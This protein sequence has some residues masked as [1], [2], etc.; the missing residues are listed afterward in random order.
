MAETTRRTCPQCGKRLPQDAPGGL[1][2]RCVMAMNLSAETELTGDAGPVLVSPEEIAARLPQYEILE[3]LGRGGMGVVYKARQTAL[4]REV[5]IK[6]LA[7]QWQGDEDFAERFER[8]AK[9]LA[10]MSHPNIVTVHDF[11]DAEGLYYIVMEY[12]DGV[13]LRDLLSDGKMEPEQALAI[14]PPIC[15]ALEYAHGK[16][17]VHRDIK[18]ENLLLDREGRIKIADFGIASLAGTTKEVSGTPSY[19]APEQ[20]NGSVDRR[21]DIYAL[22]VVLYEM[23]TGE[24]PAKDGGRTVEKGRG[25]CANRRDGAAP[26]E[27]EPERRYQTAGEFRTT[28]E[29]VARTS[30]VGRAHLAQSSSASEVP[31]FSPWESTLA[32][33]GAV[34]SAAMLFPAMEV[35]SPYRILA[36][37]GF[38]AAFSIGVVSLAGFWPFPSPFFPGPNFSSRN[39][40]RTRNHEDQN[41][42]R[43]H[44]VVACFVA[45]GLLLLSTTGNAM[46]MLVGASIMLAAGLAC[47]SRG[48]FR[49]ALLI[50]LA[51]VG[52]AAAVVV[53]SGQSQNLANLVGLDFLPGASMA[54][55]DLPRL[56][57]MSSAQRPGVQYL[58][59]DH[60]GSVAGIKLPSKIDDRTRVL[61]ES[62]A[63]LMVDLPLR[64]TSWSF[65]TPVER[66]TRIAKVPVS[67]WADPG[68]LFDPVRVP[69]HAAV[70]SPDET[71]PAPKD[72]DVI[73][74]RGGTQFLGRDA[75]E[76][77]AQQR[78]LSR[79]PRYPTTTRACGSGVER[80]SV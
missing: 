15:E 38:I 34:F 46:A 50:G 40:R 77:D 63:D 39:L 28:A 61:N 29:F 31:T 54:R 48:R 35:P 41:R 10:H 23:L 9:T 43:R 60:K 36:L 66:P 21:A 37:F 70:T 8:E 18:P 58:D 59:L 24:R 62:G 49:Q 53:L 80:L 75:W 11:G 19:M 22:G 45:A 64:K 44:A 7:G 79:R 57:C 65:V 74:I 56:S 2:P 30:D 52:V 55:A 69:S 72:L 32:L 14:V 71:T 68:S 4:D 73:Q 51:G 5:A 47:C 3:F 1:C 13:N 20:E 25:G 6:V 67:V 27:K 78:S 16:G 12:V 26:L 76:K 42:H 33:A 17:V